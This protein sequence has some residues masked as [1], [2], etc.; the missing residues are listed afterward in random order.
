[1][2]DYEEKSKTWW[3]FHPL[4]GLDITDEFHD[5]DSPMFQDATIISRK[6]IRQII[7][8][9]MK[10]NEKNQHEI[11]SLFDPDP[12]F[13]WGEGFQSFIAIRRTGVMNS[14]NFRPPLVKDSYARAQRIGALLGLILLAENSHGETCCLVEQLTGGNLG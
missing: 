14:R 11:I 12:R 9:K 6:H 2:V 10:L 3:I 5:L 1:M 4:K 7:A 8:N 13:D